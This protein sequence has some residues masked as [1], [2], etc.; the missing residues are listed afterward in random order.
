MKY[1]LTSLLGILLISCAPQTGAHYQ[2]IKYEAGA[3][4]G[5]CPIFK[6]T[7]NPD[8]SA[9][10][11]AER[12]TFSDGRTKDDFSGPHEG[13]FKTTLNQDDFDKIIGMLNDLKLKDLKN[14]YGSRNVTDLPT[15]KLEVKFADGTVKKIEDYGKNGTEKLNTLYKFL[16]TLPKTQNWQKVQ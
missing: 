4:F 1:I 8:R 15:A 14:N 7:I 13:T 6:L 16:E 9:V 3:C 10:I 5:F 12:F 11:E 2:Q